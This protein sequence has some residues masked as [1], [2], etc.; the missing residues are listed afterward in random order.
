MRNVRA[1]AAEGGTDGY[2]RWLTRP[3]FT[4]CVF[5][6]FG[7]EG[8]H[9]PVEVVGALDRHDVRRPVSSYDLEPCARDRGSYLLAIQGGVSSL[10][11]PRLP[12]SEP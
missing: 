8:R 3:L 12:G 2:P 9:E 6:S 10:A 11:L 7:K 1:P 4:V 5:G